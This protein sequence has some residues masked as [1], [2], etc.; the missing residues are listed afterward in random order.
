MGFVERVARGA[1][2]RF[3]SKQKAR[4]RGG[5]RTHGQV[6]AIGASSVRHVDVVVDEEQRPVPVANFAE[7]TG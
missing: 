1:N 7:R 3:R 5:E 6:N 4:L 2:D